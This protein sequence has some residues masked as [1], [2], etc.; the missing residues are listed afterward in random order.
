MDLPYLFGYIPPK[1]LEFIYD[2]TSLSGLNSTW[3]WSIRFKKKPL[4]NSWKFSLNIFSPHYSWIINHWS[5]KSH[6]IQSIHQE[7]RSPFKFYSGKCLAKV[8][9]IKKLWPWTIFSRTK[10]RRYWLST[11]MQYGAGLLELCLQSSKYSLVDTP[12][13]PLSSLFAMLIE[14]LKFLLY[15]KSRPCRFLKFL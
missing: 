3:P 14:Y 6:F 8:S 9:I 15:A 2:N 10:N 11:S 7:I 1:C 5:S 4:Q 12:P 13:L